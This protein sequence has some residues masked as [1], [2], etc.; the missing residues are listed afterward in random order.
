MFV[1]QEKD[2]NHILKVIITN[3]TP[4]RSP[5]Q[6]PVP[7]N[8]LFLGARYA[9]YHANTE[10]L[11]SL[12]STALEKVNDV[13][14]RNQWDMTL[15][16]F[17]MSNAT[18]LLYYLKKD[19]G[20]NSATP[21]FQ[22]HT[23]DLINEIYILIIRDA[24]RRID[25]IFDQALL[26]YETIPGF[27]DVHFQNEWKIFRSKTKAKAPE[28]LET[29]YRPPS[30]KRRAQISPRNVTSLLSSTLFVLDLYDIHSVIT[31]Q[32]I[33]QLFYWL[34]TEMFNRIMSN[35]KY[36]ARTKA[37]QIRMNVSILEDWARTNDR[38]AEHYENGSMTSTG[39]TFI[40]MVRRHLAPT[41]Q[42]LQWL[43]CFSS[44]G[45][46]FEALAATLQQLPG[47][48]PQQLLHAANHYRAE[49]GEKSL[50]KNAIKYLTN[51]R[52]EM[53]QKKTKERET[54]NNNAKEN[55]HRYA[56]PSTQGASTA[57]EDTCSKPM[58]LHADAHG[59]KLVDNLLFDPAYML[60]FLLPTSTDMLVSYGAG[61]GGVNKEQ[62]RKY[63]P[64]VPPEV[65]TKLD[66]S[67]LK[68]ESEV[69]QG[70]QWES[71]GTT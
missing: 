66:I 29:M 8:I 52:K 68:G 4:Q 14:E 1:F 53:A 37:M 11:E 24:E 56:S 38:K 36:L 15:L 20:L 41:V 51:L 44:L 31:A 16:A 59:D 27:E 40:D 10:L 19:K 2:L 13:V 46:D 43:Q 65:L 34:G 32:V 67:S 71:R 30:P 61:F 18:L 17:W 21:D 5:S 62:E 48:V 28:S 12:L 63:V 47:L 55:P 26:D 25:K 39:E 58:S 22:A 23:A 54:V 33:S 3:M 42:L 49:V 7:A 6:K 57:G 45:D 70:S 69:Y 50:P 9:F 64:T 60:P 35:K